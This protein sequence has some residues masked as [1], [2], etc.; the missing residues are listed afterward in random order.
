[1]TTLSD[2]RRPSPTGDD[3]HQIVTT[4]S[5]R[6]RPSPTGGCDLH[7][8]EDAT[9][10]DQ[11]TRPSLTRRDL[12]RPED[13]TFT[14][15]RTRP[16]LNRRDLRRPENATFAD[17]RTRP[18]PTCSGRT[19]KSSRIFRIFQWLIVSTLP[20]S[21]YC[22]RTRRAPASPTTRARYHAPSAEN[23]ATQIISV[24]TDH[25]CKNRSSL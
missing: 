16:S 13:A 7:R 1:M 3:R 22:T 5:D 15:Q 14:D 2:W 10:T 17:R 18:S 24:R 25:L 23:R 20:K 9:F 12:H 21:T 8:P 11:R 19:R 6:T 4:F